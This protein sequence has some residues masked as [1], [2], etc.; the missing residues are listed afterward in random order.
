VALAG[1]DQAPVNPTSRAAL[2]LSP[3]LAPASLPETTGVEIRDYWFSPNIVTVPMGGVVHWVLIGPKG[4][5]ATDNTGLSLYN[6]GAMRPGDVFDYRFR[7]SGSYAFYCLPHPT[8]MRG[9]VEVPVSIV[10]AAGRLGDSFAVTWASEPPDSDF[11]SDVQVLDPGATAWRGWQSGVTT[12]AGVFVPSRNGLHQFRARI[13]RLTDNRTSGW[14]PVAALMVSSSTATNL[15]PTPGFLV[16]C[17]GLV[18]S[19]QDQTVD[20]D[21]FIASWSWS[22]GEGVTSTLQNPSRTYTA[23]RTYSV[24][25]SATDNQSASATYAR[26]LTPYNNAPYADF[27]LSCSELACSFT[28]LSTDSDG[29]VVAWSWTFGDGATSTEQNPTHVYAAA[30][31]YTVTLG[32]TDNSGRASSPDTLAIQVRADNV[33]P[34]ASFTY[35]CSGLTCTFTDLSTDTDGQIVGWA[36]SFGDG[37]TSTVQNPVHTFAVSGS[38]IVGLRV[39][40]DLGALS[41]EY[42]K[43]VRP[44]DGAPP[45]NQA[46]VAAFTFTC[47]GLTCDFLDGSS[48][49]D[50]TVVS[51]AWSFGD[52][53]TDAIPS[54]SHAFPDFGSYL[55]SLTVTDDSGATSTPASATVTLTGISLSATGYTVSGT[56]LVDLRWSGATGE[57]VDLYRNNGLLGSPINDGELTDNTIPKRFGVWTYRICE[58]GTS[59]CSNEATVVF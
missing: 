33:A 9:T 22:L 56:P 27:T 11:V 43:E 26:G 28:D 58:R 10:P 38:Y 35:S 23:S 29:S 15:T 42:T 36:W 52:G 51:W 59:V 25:L 18:C 24:R 41:V 31:T 40:D 12:T 44:T 49:A 55:V 46:P 17:S 57:R 1:C 53:G 47:S 50:G 21:G 2:P 54:P 16:S 14:S 20:A 4:H 3:D 19:F 45:P 34:L 7:A 32:S 8:L 39:I 13:R 5:T 48:D 6:S 30:S 37:S